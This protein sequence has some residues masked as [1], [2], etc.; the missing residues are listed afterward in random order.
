MVKHKFC[1]VHIFVYSVI[2]DL[3]D[4]HL[5]VQVEKAFRKS[6]LLLLKAGNHKNF[7]LFV[8]VLLRAA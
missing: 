1:K 6:R 3:L 4:V 7:L 8:S 2:S 5:R